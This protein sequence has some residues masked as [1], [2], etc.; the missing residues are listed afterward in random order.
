MT[1]TITIHDP[2][3]AAMFETAAPT[4]GDIPRA[5][6]LGR[7]E[8]G[9]T[10]KDFE[11]ET[12]FEMAEIMVGI[13][14][15]SIADVTAHL[16]HEGRKARAEYLHILSLTAIRDQVLEAAGGNAEAPFLENLKALMA[17]HEDQSPADA[18]P[19]ADTPGPRHP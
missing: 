10:R 19:T 13:E 5:I 1:E 11:D 18:E 17:A 8:D 6:N 12:E 7:T 3:L 16:A 4:M 14:H 2:E 9:R 15:A